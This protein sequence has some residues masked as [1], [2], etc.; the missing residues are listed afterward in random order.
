MDWKDVH[1]IMFDYLSP[2]VVCWLHSQA[3]HDIGY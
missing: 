3:F 1:D 2:I